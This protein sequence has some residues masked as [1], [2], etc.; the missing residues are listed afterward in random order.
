MPSSALLC[1]G[2][3]CAEPPV[4]ADVE[5]ELSKASSVAETVFPSGFT[6]S[7]VVGRAC[8]GVGMPLLMRSKAISAAAC[9]RPSCSALEAAAFQEFGDTDLDRTR[10]AVRGNCHHESWY[11]NL[12][13]DKLTSGLAGREDLVSSDRG[14]E[15]REDMGERRESTLSH[16]IPGSVWHRVLRHL[17]DETTLRA[18]DL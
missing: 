12:E 10:A 11:P 16:F 8:R 9:A 3:D 15:G 18:L 17:E 2:E 5:I 6:A 14:D 7:G 1:R 4:P 13:G